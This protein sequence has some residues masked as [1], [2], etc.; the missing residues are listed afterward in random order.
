MLLYHEK[1]EISV[2]TGDD[3]T[4]CEVGIKCQQK[5]VHVKVNHKMK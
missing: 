5:I 1:P 4:S 3:P 2:S